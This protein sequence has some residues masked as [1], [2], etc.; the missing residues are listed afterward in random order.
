[1]Y[2][3]PYVREGVGGG[4]G[5]S[6]CNNVEYSGTRIQCRMRPTADSVPY[7]TRSGKINRAR[8]KIWRRRNTY[9]RK[10]DTAAHLASSRQMIFSSADGGR[11]RNMFCLGRGAGA[12]RGCCNR[13][14]GAS[15]HGVTPSMVNERFAKS[16]CCSRFH[17]S[18][19]CDSHFRC[20]CS[21]LN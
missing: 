17:E 3:D 11:L 4:A 20:T 14:W 9:S 10:H 13:A 2:H 21:Q 16:R 8:R 18:N 1:M 15:T 7:E 6:D 5:G 12:R 19:C